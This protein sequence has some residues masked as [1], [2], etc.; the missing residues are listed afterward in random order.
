MAL[1]GESTAFYTGNAMT[2]CEKLLTA[3][4]NKPVDWNEFREPVRAEPSRPE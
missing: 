4:Q 2:R 3:L 1:A